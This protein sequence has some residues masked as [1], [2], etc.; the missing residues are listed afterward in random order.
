VS[1]QVVFFDRFVNLLTKY[2]DRIAQ[3]AVM[4]MMLLV[5]GDIVLRAAWRPIPGTYDVVGFIGAVLVSFSIAYCAVKKGHIS[6]ELLV[7]RFPQRAQAIISTFTGVLS[8][9]IFALIT[10][11]CLVLAKDMWQVGQVS[12]SAH[13]PFYPYIYGVAFGC[14]LLCLVILVDLGKSLTE[15]VRG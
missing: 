3:A 11:Q 7:A 10:W 6:V 4:G 14:A 5:A 9:G 2:C 1:G 12:M 8:L 15:A 13:I